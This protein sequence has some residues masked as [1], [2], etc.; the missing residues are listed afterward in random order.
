MNLMAKVRASEENGKPN[1]ND[2]PEPLNESAINL[3][4]LDNAEEPK[5]ANNS[6]QEENKKFKVEGL[7]AVAK[8]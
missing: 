8:K 2:E 7:L 3:V 6:D 1:E 4:I 5:E